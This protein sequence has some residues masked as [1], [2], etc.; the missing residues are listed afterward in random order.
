MIVDRLTHIYVA[1]IEEKLLY[2]PWKE[3]IMIVL[4]KPGKPR[5]D[6]PKVYVPITLLNMMWKVVMVVVASHITYIMEKHQ[7]L[8]ANHFRGQPGQTTT[9]MM[10][11]LINKIKVA[12]CAE[13]VSL[14]LF[15]DIEGAF[16]NANL[17]RLVHNLQKCR[18]PKKYASF[19]HNMLRDRVISLKF[20]RYISD[21]IAIDNGIGQGDPLSMVLYQY[22]NMD[23]LNIPS[24]KD[25][26]AVAYVDNT[27]MIATGTNFQ[28]THHVLVDMMCKE[29]GVEDWSKTYSSPLKYI[30]LMLMNFAHSCKKLNSPTLHLL[31]RSIQPVD[32]MKYLGVVFNR[33]LNWK[34]Q[35]AHA[36]EKGTKWVA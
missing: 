29:G 17:E 9:D 26:E 12:W 20:D 36:V 15:L 5:Y 24:S 18:I 25:K 30:K 2:K 28:S 21:P 11:L 34:V 13:K 7:L 23:L 3:F 6:M 27:F 33:N 16:P 22:Y 32:G 19:I 35:Q 10:H 8:P 14:V 4:R 1:L 31:H